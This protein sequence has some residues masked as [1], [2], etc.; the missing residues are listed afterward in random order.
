MGPASEGLKESTNHLWSN[1]C[2]ARVL[3]APH[4]SCMCTVVSD[5][6]ICDST[7]HI[8]RSHLHTNILN[9]QKM[10]SDYV[11]WLFM[12][13]H[14][15]LL[16][17]TCILIV[18]HW[19]IGRWHV[20]MLYETLLHTLLKVTCMPIHW[21]IRKWYLI[22]LYEILLH[23]LFE[24]TCIPIHWLIRRWRVITL[25]ETPQHTL[26]VW[27]YMC[28]CTHTCM[29]VC[30]CVCV[31]VHECMHVCMHM[32]V[33]VC[34]CMHVCMCMCVWGGVI[35]REGNRMFARIALVVHLPGDSKFL[36]LY[37]TDV[38]Q[39]WEMSH[40]ITACLYL[41]FLLTR[42]VW[43]ADWPSLRWTSQPCPGPTSPCCMTVMWSWLSCEC[44]V[45]EDLGF[46]S[47]HEI[48]KSL[49]LTVICV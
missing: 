41:H 27:V 45:Q 6:V 5:Y 7:A 47:V 30:V 13:L 49:L 35:D 36:T 37:L 14:C 2:F 4:T 32:C 39:V 46:T 29:C 21:I 28:G 23:T 1:T 9:N 43:W 19:I 44:T 15:T 42:W 22:T 11:I 3:A 31:C 8:I 26:C 24:V 16:E 34:A 12:R 40:A 48:M 18:T 20:I 33:F 10:A 25:Y 17:V 38:K